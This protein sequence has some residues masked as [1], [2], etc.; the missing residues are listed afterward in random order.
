[1]KSTIETCNYFAIITVFS[2]LFGITNGCFLNSC[3]FRRYGRN[4]PCDTCNGI[5]NGFCAIEGLCCNS[6]KC[7]VDKDCFNKNICLNDQ[8]LIDDIPGVCVF[9]GLCCSHGIC[10][11]VPECFNDE[12]KKSLKLI[13]SKI[14]FSFS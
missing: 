6:N 10:K 4:V 11:V 13:K 12:R 9:S 8:C 2:L 1:M 14:G 3:P 7:L 5:E